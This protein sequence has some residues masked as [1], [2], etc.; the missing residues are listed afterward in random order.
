MKSA[1]TERS[2]KADKKGLTHTTLVVWD[3]PLFVRRT[4]KTLF[5]GKPKF[6]QFRGL[7]S[8]YLGK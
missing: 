2:S 6:F 1:A 7:S 3:S 5:G 4:E 8:R